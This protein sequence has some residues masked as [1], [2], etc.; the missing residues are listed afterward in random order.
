MSDLAMTAEPS[1]TPAPPP[2]DNSPEPV[3]TPNPIRTDAPPKAPEQPEKPKSVRES[4]VEAKAKIEKQEARLDFSA[5]AEAAERQVRA[6]NP[7]P[8]AFF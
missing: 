3:E 1:N 6:F 7:L 8:G 5:S 4:V 2:V